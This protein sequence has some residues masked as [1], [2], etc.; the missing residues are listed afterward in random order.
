MFFFL[1]VLIATFTLIVP[2]SPTIKVLVRAIECAGLNP[3]SGAQPLALKELY[4]LQNMALD[5]VVGLEITLCLR[6]ICLRLAAPSLHQLRQHHKQRVML[7]AIR[8]KHKSILPGALCYVLGFETCIRIKNNN[9][10][11]PLI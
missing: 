7:L 5:H 3:I 9:V 8:E 1:T 4:S 6:P 2:A 10:S 11:E